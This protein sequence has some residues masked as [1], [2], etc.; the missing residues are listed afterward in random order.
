VLTRHAPTGFAVIHRHPNGEITP[1]GHYPTN[2][3]A[4]AV[5]D[6]IRRLSRINRLSTTLEQIEYRASK[7]LRE[8]EREQKMCWTQSAGCK[9]L[10][11][12]SKELSHV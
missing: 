5:A 3:E 7:R 12:F 6:E 4:D 11:E 8:R 10:T 1:I 2:Q 9:P